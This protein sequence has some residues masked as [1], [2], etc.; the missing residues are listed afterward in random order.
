M[1]SR[2]KKK[3]D[4]HIQ[5]KLIRRTA[6]ACY[7]HPIKAPIRD[8]PYMDGTFGVFVIKAVH[9]CQK[10]ACKFEIRVQI[11]VK[12]KFLLPKNIFKDDLLGRFFFVLFTPAAR[13]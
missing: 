8:I 7:N 3:E 12:Y 1:W 10:N 13:I 4:Y 11:K 5:I 2:E 9:Y 6:V